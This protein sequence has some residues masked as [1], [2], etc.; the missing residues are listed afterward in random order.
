VRAATRRASTRSSCLR[1]TKVRQTAFEADAPDGRSRCRPTRSSASGPRD[2]DARLRPEACPMGRNVRLSI[3]ETTVR[4]AG[5]PDSFPLVGWVG[6][7]RLPR[8]QPGVTSSGAS[9]RLGGGLSFGGGQKG[10]RAQRAHRPPGGRRPVPSSTLAL[11][12]PTDNRCLSDHPGRVNG[13]RVWPPEVLTRVGGSD[14]P[15]VGRRGLR[16][17]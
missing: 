17:V 6:R 16:R 9:T 10:E 14:T 2:Q 11:T 12:P 7:H 1:W 15:S 8:G 13:G 4:G 3:G 5:R